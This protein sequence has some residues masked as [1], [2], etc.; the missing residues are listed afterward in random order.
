MF[1][2]MHTSGKYHGLSSYPRV[3]GRPP[4]PVYIDQD[5]VDWNEVNKDK[6]ELEVTVT[7][8]RGENDIPAP[9]DKNQGARFVT[10]HVLEL[11]VVQA[12][13]DDKNREYNDD[14]KEISDDAW[15]K[16]QAAVNGDSSE[17]C[18]KVAEKIS[19]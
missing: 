3:I 8:K 7:T 6:T 19:E 15:K 14:A 11:M 13:F 4:K 16:A 18:K 1:L 12:A 10:D 9:K 5:N 2:A 17:N